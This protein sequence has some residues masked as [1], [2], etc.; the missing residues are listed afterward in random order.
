MGR[1][2]FETETLLAVGGF[3]D[4]F[5]GHFDRESYEESGR[6]VPISYRTAGD[7]CVYEE[8]D[9]TAP[10]TTATD[11]NV[12]ILAFSCKDHGSDAG[13]IAPT[14]RSMGHDGS[15]ANGGGQVAVAMNLRGRDGGAMPE[16]SDVAS[17]RAASGG[18]SRS[19]VAGSMA[20]RRLTPTEC[21][22]L[23]AFPDGYTAITRKG[24]P[25]ADGPRYKALGNSWA[26][27]CARWI[28]ERIQVVDRMTGK[29]ETI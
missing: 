19:Y 27:L 14:L 16:L 10:L 18:S 13:E 15:H 20:V 29:E 6:L 5:I 3:P 7:G 25:A 22:R 17:L 21:E 28:V 1:Q 11:P 4:S 9:R 12:N 23:Q 26:V 24:K 8:G 2:D